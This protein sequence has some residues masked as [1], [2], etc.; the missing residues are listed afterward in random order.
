MS[1]RKEG[2][3]KIKN[4]LQGGIGPKPSSEFWPPLP[5]LVLWIGF[6]GW[7]RRDGALSVHGLGDIWA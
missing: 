3:L 6:G 5:P 7:E 2:S 4:F 1:V